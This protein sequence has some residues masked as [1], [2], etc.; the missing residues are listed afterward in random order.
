MGCGALRGLRM[1]IITY[2]LIRD[3]FA[4]L[5]AD[6]ADYLLLKNQLTITTC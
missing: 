3:L 6:E 4:F 2:Y 1:K 5:L